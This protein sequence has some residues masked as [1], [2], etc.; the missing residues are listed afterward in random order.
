MGYYWTISDKGILNETIFQGSGAN[1]SSNYVGAYAR[2]FAKIP[3]ASLDNTN[4][5]F[6]TYLFC[7]YAWD[8]VISPDLN[9]FVFSNHYGWN[10]NSGYYYFVLFQT[11]K[12]ND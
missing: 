11:F 5:Q 2:I 4:Y 7:D 9:V 12:F 1:S 3:L 8:F 6:A 10:E